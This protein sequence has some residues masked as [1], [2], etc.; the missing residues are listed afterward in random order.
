MQ[1]LGGLSIKDSQIQI[2]TRN[3]EDAVE[4]MARNGGVQRRQWLSTSI[5][6]GTSIETAIVQESLWKT[7]LE[8]LRK[9]QLLAHYQ[10]LSH[11][12]TRRKQKLVMS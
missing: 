8:R 7:K 12:V 1:W 11:R 2:P 3:L 5:V 4:Q 6:S 10:A 9:R